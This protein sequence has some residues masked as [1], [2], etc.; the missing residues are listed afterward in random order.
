MSGLP[1]GMPATS[2]KGAGTLNVQP[3][4]EAIGA[5]DGAFLAHVG[6]EYE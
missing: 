4:R 1:V 3:A 2:D 6:Q 5:L